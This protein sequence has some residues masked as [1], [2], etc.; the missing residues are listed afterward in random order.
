MARKNDDEYGTMDQLIAM[1]FL[2]EDEQPEP[3]VPNDCD[4]CGGQG[5]GCCVNADI[6]LI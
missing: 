5:V 2:V 3:L 6:P 4:D 1:R